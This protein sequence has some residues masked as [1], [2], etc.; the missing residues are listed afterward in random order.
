MDQQSV[1]LWRWTRWGS[2]DVAKV[3]ALACIG[4]GLVTFHVADLARL[5]EEAAKHPGGLRWDL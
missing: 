1:K 4:C 5:Q 2:R 3:R